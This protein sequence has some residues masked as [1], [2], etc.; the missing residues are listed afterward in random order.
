MSPS[1]RLPKLNLKSIMMW[2]TRRCTQAQP[3]ASGTKRRGLVHPAAHSEVGGVCV[4]AGKRQ[5]V[6]KDVPELGAVSV[7]HDAAWGC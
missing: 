3:R 5:Q 1:C 2:P 7:V 6:E 4:L